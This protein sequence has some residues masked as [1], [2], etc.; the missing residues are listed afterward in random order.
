M[1]MVVMLGLK[2]RI[3]FAK[4]IVKYAQRNSKDYI[5]RK[6]DDFVEKKYFVVYDNRK[7]SHVSTYT[8]EES[9]VGINLYWE[10]NIFLRQR[11]A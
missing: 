10:T 8:V 3:S 9:H 7:K 11:S 2:R 4:R 6:E 1:A 5:G